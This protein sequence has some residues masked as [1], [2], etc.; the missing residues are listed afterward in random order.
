MAI[1]KLQYE[2]MSI[3]CNFILRRKA[4]QGEICDFSEQQQD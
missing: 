4:Y 2:I 1:I 3:F